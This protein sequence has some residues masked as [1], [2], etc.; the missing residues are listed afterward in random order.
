[1]AFH[2]ARP[3]LTD[4]LVPTSQQLIKGSDDLIALF[5]QRSDLLPK[6]LPGNGNHLEEIQHDRPAL[7]PESRIEAGIGN[8]PGSISI[9]Y[10][11]EAHRAPTDP[12]WLAPKPPPETSKQSH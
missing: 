11:L 6:M 2:S 12:P 7:D 5:L 4:R 1:M 8:F 10:F 9:T 3:Q